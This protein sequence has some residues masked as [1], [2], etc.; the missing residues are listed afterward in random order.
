MSIGHNKQDGKSLPIPFDQ[1]FLN[2][3][4]ST[5]HLDFPPDDPFHVKQILI[6]AERTIASTAGLN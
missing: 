1:I 5:F 3:P 6:F 4:S 2:P